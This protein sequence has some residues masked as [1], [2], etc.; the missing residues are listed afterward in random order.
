[1]ATTDFWNDIQREGQSRSQSNQFVQ[2]MVGSY[3]QMLSVQHL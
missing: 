3:E 2:K 1:M